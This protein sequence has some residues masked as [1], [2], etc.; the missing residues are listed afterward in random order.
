MLFNS[1]AFC[2]FFISVLGLYWSARPEVRKWML[3]G[4]SYFF[5]SYA[6]PP[7]AFLLAS[8]TAINFYIGSRI[9][10]SRNSA[11]LFLILGIVID[12]SGIGLYK[13]ANFLLETFN[14]AGTL[15]GLSYRFPLLN[16]VLPIGISFYTFQMLSYLI[17]IYRGAP[18][19][20][21]LRDFALYVSFF[22][23]LVAGPIVRPSV[24]I[25]QLKRKA[26]ADPE[27][28]SLGMFLLAQG[29]VKKIVFAD[30]L[31]NHVDLVFASPGNFNSISTLIA[32]Y[33]YA[34]QIYFDFSGYTDI[35]IGCGKLLGFQI[36]D[37]FNLPYMARNLREFWQR[38]HISLSTWLRDY[39]YIPL[40]G[41]RKGG[42][43]RT[44]LNLGI[45]M[46]LGGLWHGANWTFVIWG[47]YH[48]VLIII[49]HMRRGSER[50]RQR[51][52]GSF[53]L[54]VLQ[55]LITF[56]LVCAGWVIFRS[57]NLMHAMVIFRNLLALNISGPLKGAPIII[58]LCVA[59]ASHVAREKWNLQKWFVSLP[60]PMQGWA[61]SIVAV[62]VYLFFSVEEGFIYFQF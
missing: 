61:Y 6:H 53:T 22:P 29:F 36:P 45:T 2:F 58:M 18:A 57:E 26:T 56:H 9:S 37:N 23:Q 46:V 44:Y 15:C 27:Q 30:F 24:L 51:E 11:R 10:K 42:H 49:N 59:A 40:G 5:Y 50:F 54:K 55:V 31:G 47:F 28:L 34:F 1:L 52:N 12:L 7:Y 20:R 25:P 19:E 41:S 3:L 48:G 16:L 43:R 35:A 38:W 17:D 62:A 4:A 32:M 33:A 21:S 8:L 13:Y 39:L 14:M 60:G